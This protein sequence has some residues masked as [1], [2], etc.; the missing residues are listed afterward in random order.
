M[1]NQ[2]HEPLKFFGG[3]IRGPLEN[4]TTFEKEAYAIYDVFRKREYLLIVEANGRLFTDHRN[5]L[6][7]F[8]PHAMDFTSEGTGY[9]KFTDG[10]YFYPNFH[11]PLNM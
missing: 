9:V 2:I 4:W 1:E 11:T 7:V 8:H 5:L 3:R 6:F 10:E